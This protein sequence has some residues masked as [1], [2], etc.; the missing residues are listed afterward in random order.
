MMND[1]TGYLIE[2]VSPG[3]P[4]SQLGIKPGWKLLRIDNKPIG[5]IID[6]KIMESDESP[7]LILQTDRGIVR[8]VKASK[9]AGVP[10]GLGFDPPTIAKMQCCGNDCIFC[11]IRQ[12]PPGLRPAL[13]IK[14]DDYR[15]SFLFGN[16]I[17]L[18]RLNEAEI[19][20]IIKL[21]LSP[22][23]VSVHTTNPALRKAMFRTKNAE[24]GLKNLK[25]LTGAGIRVHAQIVLCPGINTGAEMERTIRDLHRLGSNLTDIALVPVGLTAH[26][27][28]LTALRK[29]L[30]EEAAVLIE[31][32]E[33]LQ[34]EFLN[35]RK[36]R[37]LFLADEFYILAGSEFPEDKHYEGYPQLE[38]GVGLARQ[39]LNELDA[40]AD[41]K[42]PV[43]REKLTVTVASGMAAAFLIKR[44]AG[45]FLKIDKLTV[46]PVLVKNHFFGND[47]TVS[48]LLTGSDI[49]IA[50]EGKD[51]GDTL[52]I[53]DSLL[54][55]NSD[56]FIDDMSKSK[57][58]QIL[59]V[60]ICAVK[61]PLEMLAAIRHIDDDRK[62]TSKRGAG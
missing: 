22:L 62:L 57:L 51:L 53:A 31:R 52:F 42:L 14:D 44:L 58:E 35:K 37:F 32:I 5:D 2:R 3:S 47:V 23:Y 28:K 8:R 33:C 25:R 40:V 9:P 46:N 19:R 18:N 50:M 55:E 61:G 30:P 29:F 48:G 21:Q 59:K 20:R 49:R 60:N 27:R 13:Y 38:N 10:L 17:T 26:R 36:S 11:F 41:Q 24:N 16:F 1:K 43:L 39:F 15:L 54:R 6:Y 45:E 4:A 7:R 56:V 34:Q 12:N